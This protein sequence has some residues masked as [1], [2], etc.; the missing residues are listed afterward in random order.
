MNSIGTG[1]VAIPLAEHGVHVDGLEAS[2][3]MAAHLESR[4]GDLPVSVTIADMTAFRAERPY[5][6]VYMVAST[7]TLLPTQ[8]DQISCLASS[9]DALAPG[10]P[11]RPGDQRARHLRSSADLGR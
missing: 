8:E 4:R 9:V 11:S 5:S 3:A 7:F 10:G 1:R 2:P 6:L